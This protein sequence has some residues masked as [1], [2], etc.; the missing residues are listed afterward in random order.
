MIV[1]EGLADTIALALRLEK[2]GANRIELVSDIS[3]GG[4][5]PSFGF[6]KTVYECVQIPLVVMIRPRVGNFIYSSEELN[7]MQEDIRQCNL[8]GVESVALGILDK[9]SKIDVE[10][11]NYVLKF[12]G[13]MNVVFHKAFDEVKHSDEELQKLV[14]LNVNRVLTSGFGP[15][16]LK[17]VFSL[18]QL[19]DKWGSHINFVAAGG[20][21]GHHIREINEVAGIAQFHGSRIFNIVD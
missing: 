16:A 13:E 7:C 2:Q 4:V 5:T 11:M 15:S 20:V 14:D 12:K 19:H 6:I 18:Q 3:H 1:K 8:I 21:L 10:A 17:G 9:K